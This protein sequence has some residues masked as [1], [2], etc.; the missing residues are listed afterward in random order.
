MKIQYIPLP[1]FEFPPTLLNS[2]QDMVYYHLLHFLTAMSEMNY[3]DSN[4]F[5]TLSEANDSTS[6][7]KA[8]K[9]SKPIV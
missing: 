5:L 3:C 9:L 7:A 1:D 2:L 8:V 4:Y 6:V